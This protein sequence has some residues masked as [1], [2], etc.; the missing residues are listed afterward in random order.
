MGQIFWSSFF[1]TTF[2]VK[3]LWDNS[4]GQ[5]SMGQLFWLNFFGTI[6]LVKFFWDNFSG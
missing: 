5:V 6:F 2:L 3:F 4:F 1:G